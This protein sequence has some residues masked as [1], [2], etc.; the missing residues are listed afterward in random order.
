LNILFIPRD[1]ERTDSVLLTQTS[2]GF[3]CSR[4]SAF[5]RLINL[6]SLTIVFQELP[7]WLGEN[8]GGSF[9]RKRAFAQ[10]FQIQIQINFSG[11]IGLP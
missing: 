9:G 8:P 10:L 2:A 1:E 3:H 4:Q 5:A 11:G 7:H 6:R